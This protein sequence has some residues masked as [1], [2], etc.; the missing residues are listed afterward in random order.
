M[1]GSWKGDTLAVKSA[2]MAWFVFAPPGDH[3]TGITVQLDGGKTVRSATLDND[4]RMMYRA[5]QH[6][7]FPATGCKHY[8]RISVQE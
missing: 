3:G 8:Y 6:D 2:G 5:L 7:G 1:S 4:K